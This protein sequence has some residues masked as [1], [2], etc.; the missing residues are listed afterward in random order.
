[1]TTL[2]SLPGPAMER[3]RVVN[4]D[5][6]PAQV[7]RVV[8]D[9]VI[10]TKHDMFDKLTQSLWDVN[11]VERL[12]AEAHHVQQEI[13]RVGIAS[14]VEMYLDTASTKCGYQI[15]FK[16]KEPKRI[17]GGI[18]GT[19]GNAEGGV[20]LAMSM[21]NILG[22]GERLTAD[23]G[24]GSRTKSDF[25]LGLQFPILASSTT[26]RTVSLFRRNQLFDAS[27]INLSENGVA[28]SANANYLN[29]LIKHRLSA[30]AA[31][32]R[33]S[34]QTL[35]TPMQLR[36]QSGAYL[37]TSVCSTL[38]IDERD[39]PI[40]ATDGGFAQL[41]SEVAFGSS[42]YVKND[43]Q[44]Q[45]NVPAGP[46]SFQASIALGILSHVTG[47]KPTVVD[48]FFLGGPL[49]LRGFQPFHAGPHVEGCATGGNCYYVGALHC[50]TLVPFLP[51]DSSISNVLRL[52]TFINAGSVGDVSTVHQLR[53]FLSSTTVRCSYG[54]GLVL[55]F[56]QAARLELN[57]VVP[58][59][60]QPGDVL[61][62]RKCAFAFGVTYS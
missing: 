4:A 7:E 18:H 8:F 23:T 48:K 57:Y 12:I 36:E 45:F 6:I 32:R 46:I 21:P 53:P 51:A 14:H 55:A 10:R 34:A 33:I 26:D 29:R 60:A 47:Q 50:Y 28:V 56:A 38:T 2:S 39:H 41:S 3:D 44:A 11:N 31:M 15:T 13:K 62:T 22:R 54:F 52:Q 25:N 17:V 40:L 58:L 19:V 37:K 43:L 20:R 35:S 5:E 1:M 27:A 61:G 42:S 9:G 24:Y 30:E 16:V 49:M 59:Q